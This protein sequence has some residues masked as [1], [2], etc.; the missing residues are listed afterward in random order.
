MKIAV[1]SSVL[2]RINKTGVDYYTRDLL[3]ETIKIMPNDNFILCYLKFLGRPEGDLELSGKNVA[4]KRSKLLPGK[5]YNAFERYFITIP[6]DWVTRVRAD[7]YLYPNFIYWPLMFTNRS[8]IIV[9]D[10]G[11]ID[12]PDAIVPRHRKYLGKFVPYSIKKATHVIAISAHTKKRIVE[13]YGTSPDKISVVTPAVDHSIFKPQSHPDISQVKNKY[14]IDGDYLLF[15][16]TIE[17]RKNIVGLLESYY[18]LPE[19]LKKK[20]KVVLAGGK[21]W[22]DEDINAWCEKLGE[23][24]VRT[25]YIDQE[26][27]AALYSG[28]TIFTYPSSYEGWGMQPLEAMACGTPVITANNSSLPEA[29]GEAGIMVDAGDR[30]QLTSEIKRVLTDSGLHDRM[31]ADGYE[32]AATFSWQ[33]SAK[34][35][36]KVI[37]DTVGRS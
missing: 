8:I 23:R 9:H 1:E 13:V 16:G 33:K 37:E 7:V 12:M 21:G 24:V 19:E 35:L 29:V 30:Q 27:K 34:D 18:N 6:Y 25:G 26:D 10:L 14:K 2:A 15:L 4:I 5:I 32:Q 3:R 28:A 11:Y 17:P 22:L 36:K 20:Y 31:V